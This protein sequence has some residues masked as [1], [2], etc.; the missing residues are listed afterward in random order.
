MRNTKLLILALA[1]ICGCNRGTPLGDVSGTIT[2]QGKPVEGIK[3]ELTPIAGGRTSVGYT[4][5]TGDYEMQ[6][7][8][9]EAGAIIGRHKVTLRA[10]PPPGSPQVNIPPEYGTKSQ[11]EFDVK[12]SDNRLDISL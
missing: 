4:D 10:F 7:T 1:V 11:V 12:S 8:L 3:V 5:A 2:Y 6:Y 9:S